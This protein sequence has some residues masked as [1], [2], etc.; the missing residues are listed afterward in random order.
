MN[1]RTPA[2][3]QA[4]DAL[5]DHGCPI[6]GE[7]A[8][9]LTVQFIDAIRISPCNH[10]VVLDDALHMAWFYEQLHTRKVRGNG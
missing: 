4:Y 7:T 5:M 1:H 8:S 10:T 2:I 6:C 3:E 9:E